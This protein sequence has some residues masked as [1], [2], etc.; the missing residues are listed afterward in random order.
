MKILVLSDSHRNGAAI[1]R[2][3]DKESDINEIFF[4]GDM[5]ADMEDFCYMYPQKRFHIL[6]G[7]CDMMSSYQSAG[8]EKYGEISLFYTHG[9]IY[10]V[11]SGI[12]YL[13][14]AARER[15]CRIALYGHTHIPKIDI[16]G[17]MFVINPGSVGSPR[18][19]RPTYAVIELEG[20]KIL[21]EIKYAD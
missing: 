5:A 2:V 9:H 14:S 17:D 19:S 3:L 1:D 18:A 15:G 4:L 8:I 20:T 11:K 16:I 13:V 6:S 12:D 7:N 10:R 21:P